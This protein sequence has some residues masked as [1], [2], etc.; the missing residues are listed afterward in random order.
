M[1]ESRHQSNRTR[2]NSDPTR[3]F[4]SSTMTYKTASEYALY[5]VPRHSVPAA[6]AIRSPSRN[7]RRSGRRPVSRRHAEWQPS[8]LPGSPAGAVWQL[9]PCQVMVRFHPIG[10]ISMR[11]KSFSTSS[12]APWRCFSL[13]LCR[14]VF[15]CRI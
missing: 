7:S 12:K 13:G 6:M 14:G 15:V 4:V 5:G 11:R 9:T 2:G 10:C 8:R 3:S 1:K